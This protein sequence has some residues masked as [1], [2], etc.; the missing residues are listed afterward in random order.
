MSLRRDTLLRAHSL[1][2][3]KKSPQLTRRRQNH[4]RHTKSTS[5]SASTSPESTTSSRHSLT[6]STSS[7]R[8][9]LTSATSSSRQSLT[10]STSSSRHSLTS[11]STK[12]LCS[13][14]PASPSKTSS[15]CDCVADNVV[16]DV[17]GRQRVE[18]GS[19]ESVTSRNNRSKHDNGK[20]TRRRSIFSI[21]SFR[22]LRRLS[23]AGF[24][25]SLIHI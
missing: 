9:S 23:G 4:H 5:V 21:P 24:I 15:S 8:H 25:L 1:P 13:S 22:P 16:G 19:V 14:S 3:A 11:S 6:S 18:S 2:D 7:S 12:T 20:K 17:V 10:S